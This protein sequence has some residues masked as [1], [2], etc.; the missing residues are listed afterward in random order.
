MWLTMFDYA[1]RATIQ[2]E[3]AP[4]QKFLWINYVCHIS[5]REVAPNYKTLLRKRSLKQSSVQLTGTICHSSA[6]TH[7]FIAKE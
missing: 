7:A 1:R 6:L 2:H 5:V 4:P 3:S